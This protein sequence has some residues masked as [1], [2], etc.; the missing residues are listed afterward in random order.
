MPP[1]LATGGNDGWGEAVTTPQTGAEATPQPAAG[2]TVLPTGGDDGWG[3]ST[4]PYGVLATRPPTIPE[5]ARHWGGLALRGAMEANP[6]D[7]GAN[8]WGAVADASNR[9]F[10]TDF[11]GGNPPPGR[12]YA[13]AL[14]LPEPQTPAEA[15]VAG[16]SS[17][18]TGGVLSGGLYGGMEGLISGGPSGVLPGMGRQL[19]VTARQLPGLAAVGGLQGDIGYGLPPE[20]QVPLG[21]ALGAGA[22]YVVPGMRS[23]AGVDALDLRD[24]ARAR[25]VDLS[26]IGVAPGGVRAIASATGVT[27]S[28]AAPDAAKVFRQW[29]DSG[30]RDI[31][32]DMTDGGNFT[33]RVFDDAQ[34]RTINPGYTYVRANAAPVSALN[35]SSFQTDIMALARDMARNAVTPQPRITNLTDDL[36]QAAQNNTSNPGYIPGSAAVRMLQGGSSL[37]NMIRNPANNEEANYARQLKAALQKATE[38]AMA[39][40]VL[41]RWQDTNRY[42]SNWATYKDAADPLTGQ[43]THQS[44][45]NAAGKAVSDGYFPIGGGDPG[46]NARI[47]QMFQI[48]PTQEQAGVRPGLNWRTAL[49]EAGPLAYGV[50]A[51]EAFEGAHGAGLT[52]SIPGVLYSAALGYPAAVG[53]NRAMRGI[54]GGQNTPNPPGNL[55][56]YSTLLANP[57]LWANATRPVDLTPQQQQN[58]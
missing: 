43:V 38:G 19:G 6:I 29:A 48:T 15:G 30:A 27:G 11:T 37:D 50:G 32:A 23:A 1:V 20:Y 10:G 41:K 5:V 44:L 8:M 36:L 33:K 21:M 3:E 34:T 55:A 9:Y 14:R 17:L 26:T 4:G 45:A 2:A 35:G 47:G 25:G 49:H 18:A 58:Q 7:L 24:A 42:Y 51:M 54:G 52:P 56:Y 13:D 28:G 40:D 16:A 39:P 12:R 46:L 53:V 31:G 57:G 22:G